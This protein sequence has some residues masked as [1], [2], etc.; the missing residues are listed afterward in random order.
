MV[1]TDQGFPKSHRLLRRSEFSA[2]FAGGTVRKD[3]RLVAYLLPTGGPVT[4]LG[5]VVGR[6]VRGSVPRNRLKRLIREGFRTLRA[7]LP[8]GMDVIL[9]PRHGARLSLRG[10]Q[11]SVRR[12]LGRPVAPKEKPGP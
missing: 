5:I 7:E 8:T 10:V 9:L 3:G 11:E 1:G 4:R 6:A 2:V 12:L